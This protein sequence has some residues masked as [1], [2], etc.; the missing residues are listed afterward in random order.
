MAP[1]P[2]TPH[3]KAVE[4]P[5]AGLGS[6]LE[7]AGPEPCPKCREPMAHDAVL[8]MKCG[9]D[10]AAGR[11]RETQVG[12]AEVKEVAP[13]IPE[14]SAKGRLDPVALTVVG[15]L[16][17]GAAMFAAGW[18][19]PAT[20]TTGNRAASVG[21]TALTALMQTGAG[22]LAVAIAAAAGKR[23][24]GSVE[25][26]AARIF[27]AVSAFLLVLN[28]QLHQPDLNVVLA[29]AIEVTKWLAAMGVYWLLSAVLFW[30]KPEDLSLMCGVH[31]LLYVGL[32]GLV[33]LESMLRAAAVAAP[34]VK[35]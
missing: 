11:V 8:C 16:L 21:L 1:P 9:Y 14:F 4:G 23:R 18:F 13:E 10:L 2:A 32:T 22:L 25:F 35:P 27:V 15:G 7:I 24:F 12:P 5:L 33:G 34:A 3:L 17:L 6:V 26:A 19:A 20:A 28:V 29:G 30:R 31:F